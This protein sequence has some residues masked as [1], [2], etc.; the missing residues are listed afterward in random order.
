[1]TSPYKTERFF[2]H[3]GQMEA[4]RIWESRKFQVGADE[5][6]EEYKTAR[7]CAAQVFATIIRNNLGSEY[8][9]SVIFGN[10]KVCRANALELVVEAP[11]SSPVD[12][13]KKNLDDLHNRV[14]Q[15]R[16]KMM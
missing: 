8:E 9:V 3:E 16:S 1:M 15:R 2:T 5:A 7:I 13:I 12:E 11:L 4:I 6:Y 10:V 14:F